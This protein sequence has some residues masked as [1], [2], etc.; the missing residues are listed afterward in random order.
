MVI[1]IVVFWFLFILD[2]ILF[3]YLLVVIVI[4]LFFEICVVS[5]MFLRLLSVN[6]GIM[7][8]LMVK[9][10]VSGNDD[11]GCFIIVVGIWF[12][13]FVFCVNIIKKF[14]GGNEM[15]VV[16][17]R[18]MVIENLVIFCEDLIVVWGLFW[19]NVVFFVCF[20]SFVIW[21]IRFCINLLFCG[22]LFFIWL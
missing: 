11:K 20:L 2:W 12:C 19:L 3:F 21:L 4:F 13:E 9:L 6:C 22:N 14:F 16:L 15:F 5:L 8:F 1:F 18:F 17:D 10:M 7:V